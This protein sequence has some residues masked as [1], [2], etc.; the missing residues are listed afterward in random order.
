MK[1][2]IISLIYFLSCIIHLILQTQGA[3]LPSLAAKAIIIPLLMVFLISNNVNRKSRENLLIFGGL[4]FSWTGDV[5]LELPEQN[6]GIFIA[7][8]SSFLIAHVMYSILFLS[9]P[10]ENSLLNKRFYLILPVVI[11]EGIL[12]TLLYRDMGNMRIP[13]I[14][15]S[16]I[17]MT[18]L[19]AAIN[20]ID[21]VN[22]RSYYMVLAGAILF[23]ISDSAI[24]LNKLSIEIRH[25]SILIMSTYVAAQ[26]LIVL[27]YI[28]QYWN[29]K[30]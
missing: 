15:Y 3:Y 20:R 7:G 28:N 14:V 29:Q 17:I 23:V 5:I 11:Y 8:L 18:M 27:G 2:G 25:S 1:S 19:S 12:V 22:T 10:G 30:T 24:A 26:Y 13:V 21:K 4:F 6:P 9:T 16:I